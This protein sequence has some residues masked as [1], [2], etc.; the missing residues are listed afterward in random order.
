MV[1]PV[2]AHW[3]WGGG[4]LS[5]LGFIDYAGSAL[6]HMVG[7]I[8]A[9]IGAI[10]LGPRL[11]KYVRDSKG[12]VVK[13][14]AIPGHSLTLGALGCFILWFC[15]Y[16]FNGAAAKSIA[17]LAQILATTTIAPAV[18]TVS[19]MIYTWLKN[20]KPDVSMC[21]NASLAGLVGVTAGCANVDAIGAAIIGIVSG[22]IVVVIVEFIDLKL[23]IDDP[24]GAVAVHMGNGIW[25]TIAAGL[26][27]TNTASAGVDGPIYALIH[28]TSFAEGMK[29]FGVQLLGMFCIAAW[30]VVT[31]TATF[32]LI[33]KFHGLRVTPEE[34]ITGLDITEHGLPSAYADFIPCCGSYAWIC[35]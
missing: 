19:C 31:M 2:E 16:G 8:S 23:H 15:W 25:G 11:G 14:N 24:V 21:L 13:V 29:V 34:E 26:L 5:R 6:I 33:K 3:L 20:G 30:T 17:E 32:L 12:K 27:S 28:G 1:Y 10:I 9:L 18:A 4:W 7:G 35:L 22:I